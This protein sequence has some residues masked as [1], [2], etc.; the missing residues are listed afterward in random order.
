MINENFYYIH[1]N[2]E[3]TKHKINFQG[4]EFHYVSNG[5]SGIHELVLTLAKNKSRPVYPLWII[6]D[7]DWNLIEYHEGE[8][9][10]E[11]LKEKLL[12]MAA[13]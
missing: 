13:L 4:Q 2:A 10:P 9:K 5:N 8:F 3:K 6:L 12:K 7:K 1:F 11:K